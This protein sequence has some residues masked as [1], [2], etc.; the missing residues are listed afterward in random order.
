MILKDFQG[1]GVGETKATIWHYWIGATVFVRYIDF[2]GT[3]S[4]YVD[5]GSMRAATYDPVVK[6]M[7]RAYTNKG[8][9]LLQQGQVSQLDDND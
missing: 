2:S 1:G 3:G 6:W 8:P 7:T 4:Y 9:I 5:V